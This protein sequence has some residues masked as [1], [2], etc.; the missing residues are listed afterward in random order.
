MNRWREIYNARASLL[1]L[2]HSQWLSGV[3]QSF[4]VSADGISP[5][6]SL[7][8]PSAFGICLETSSPLLLPSN[9][10]W[11]FFFFFTRMPTL[12]VSAALFSPPLTIFTPDRRYNL[13]SQAKSCA[14]TAP[15]ARHRTTSTDNLVPPH[16]PPS[17]NTSI[18]T[19]RQTS[20]LLSKCH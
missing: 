6:Y 17:K 13:Q 14:V 5:Q 11:L 18:S 9:I 16:S 15:P 20:T 2:I 10:L 19:H 7:Q 4:W 12:E 8:A 3:T 1:L